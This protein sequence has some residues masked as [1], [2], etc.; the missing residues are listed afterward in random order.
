[1]D[2]LDRWKGFLPKNAV[3]MA[4]Q[5]SHSESIAPPSQNP[6]K[7]DPAP[8]NLKLTTTEG[9]NA[10]LLLEIARELDNCPRCKLSCMGRK[11]VVV[12]EGNPNAQL[13]FVGEGP[14]E[15]E[16]TQG[17]P[18]VGMSGQL[19]DKMINAMGLSRADIFIANVVKCRPPRNRNPEPDE[20]A[21]CSPF[22]RRQISIIRPKVVVALGKFAGQTLKQ[23]ETPISRLRGRIH[24]LPH[25]D[26]ASEG[27]KLVPTFH[28]AYLLRNP[29]AKKEAWEDLQLAAKVLGL[30][31]PK[32]Q[33]TAPP[34]S[35]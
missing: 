25:W 30:T 12:G 7:I 19:L 34:S 5:I 1:M 31:I 20:V 16:D 26:E 29:P 6:A 27:I 22:L 23:E 17:R 24:D 4:R 8:A 14:G 35:P 2:K 21:S 13:M 3:A 33:P 11:T 9:E 18:F 32:T 28:P 10:R 15:N